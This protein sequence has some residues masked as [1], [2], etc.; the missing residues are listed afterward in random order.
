MSKCKSPRVRTVHLYSL[1]KSNPLTT[2]SMSPLNVSRPTISR[3]HNQFLRISRLSKARKLEG[4][5]IA[6]R[7]EFMCVLRKRRSNPQRTDTA[8]GTPVLT[9]SVLEMLRS[10]LCLGWQRELEC[11]P[12]GIQGYAVD[13]IRELVNVKNMILNLR[14]ATNEVMHVHPSALMYQL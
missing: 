5:F 3:H 13:I 2:F 7:E 14:R 12:R 10:L 1:D 6:A 4:C 8:P 11:I 9:V